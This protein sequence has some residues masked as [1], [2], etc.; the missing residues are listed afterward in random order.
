MRSK[1]VLSFFAALVVLAL[2][3]YSGGYG[4][5]RTG[6]RGGTVGCGGGC[7]GS[8]TANT[9]T[10][11][12]DSAG[13]PVTSY[14]AGMVYKVKIKGV[15]ATGTNLPY[16]GFQL[17]V[18]GLANAGTSS[19]VQAGTW[20]SLP[21]GV[22]NSG[23]TPV[24]IEHSQRL[25]PISGTGNNG[26][27]YADSITWTAPVA[28]TGSVKIYGLIN[29]VNHNPSSDD[30]GD[31]WQSAV[32]VTITEAVATVTASVHI[33]LTT[34]TNP[35]CAGSSVTFT[36]TPANGGSAPSYQWKVNGTNA[37]TN[38]VTFTS[39][40][41]ANSDVVTCVMTS[42]L[43]GVTGSPATSN[44]VTMTITPVLVPTDSITA[45]A[46]TTCAGSAVTFTAHPVNGGTAP[47]YQWKVNGNNAGSNST[48][49]TT[50]T[51]AN[52]A[53]V[54]CVMTS[55]AICASPAVVTSNP[56]TITVNPAVTAA[57]T[58]TASANGICSGVGDTFA[59]TNISNQG[60]LPILQWQVNGSNVGSGAYFYSSTSLHNGD[61]VSCILTS[62]AP[63]VT[64]P[65]VTSNQI[66]MVVNSLSA[67]GISI[68]NN[69]QQCLGTPDTFSATI[70]NGGT[71]PVFQWMVNGVNAGTNSSSFISSSLS[72]G[73]SV[74]C[75]LT[76]SSACASP[77][78][79]VS[80]P[81]VAA[82]SAPVSSAVHIAPAGDTICAGS[83]VTFTATPTHGGSAPV[84]Q[85]LL[86]GNNV[87][88]N[89]NTFTSSTFADHD[90]VSCILTS[91]AACVSPA[92]A[93]SNSATMRVIPTVTPAI[94]IS[95]PD[96]ILCQGTTA[97][98]IATS[99]N[100][101]PSPFYQ[102]K[103]DGNIVG[104]NSVNFST[105]T[106]INRHIVTCTMTSNA[107]C[108][109]PTQV[110][111]RN[112][113][114]YGDSSPV[115][116]LTPH[117]SVLICSGDSQLVT[118]GG[119]VSYAWSTGSVASSIYLSQANTYT[120]TV[121]NV[122]HCSAVSRPLT[123]RVH[124]P[125]TPLI[126]QSANVLT[127]SAGSHYQW[128][129][130]GNILAGQSAHT[131]TITQTA[132]YSVEV[133]DAQGCRA[134]SAAATY[135]YVNGIN[136]IGADLGLR[137]YP[138]PNHGA[139]TVEAPN[140]KFGEVTMY[141]VYGQIVFAEPI[142]NGKLEISGHLPAQGIYILTLK[143]GNLSETMKI[144][145]KE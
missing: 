97:A 4:S 104:T 61:V 91:N 41:L 9:I 51:L 119:G 112:L 131:L 69:S 111:S 40:T 126:S 77:A 116:T 130:G 31:K 7:H 65:T 136:T 100:G 143:D 127:A 36:A 145:V 32:P 21:A 57:L 17:S 20:G 55:N 132:S 75:M 134:I 78:T 118:A 35:T 59:I 29:A 74:T 58:I 22:Q 50:A 95:T 98:F 6:V 56:I 88:T 27:V 23:G 115:I 68:I 105:A 3:S 90:V 38:S 92:T 129:M 107:R 85:W 76:S 144:I 39:T 89:G 101:G 53:V 81:V 73:D 11:E 45:S 8:T 42:N 26:T 49:F 44:A 54:T 96:S 87:G 72:A 110:V 137:V 34:G 82:F 106:L 48:T 43:A 14:H 133:T 140:V 120:V 60:T 109:A 62:N 37:G 19:A 114:M 138:M 47:T 12:L 1:I 18:A 83:S 64:N 63:C 46:T 13:I 86:N 16:F 124:T 113:T 25:S 94:D 139:F 79:V 121:T 102:W 52:N 142:T 117:D 70:T 128:L 122:H 99:A 71:G 135:L 84:Y 2:C 93:T 125:A 33:A 108:A 24:L 10:V 5:N 30:S 103:I 141:D 123:V 15:N 80:S 67:P 28:G 66:T